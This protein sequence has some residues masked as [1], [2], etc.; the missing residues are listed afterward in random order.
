MKKNFL[1]KDLIKLRKLLLCKLRWIFC[2][3]VS[4]NFSLLRKCEVSGAG[5]RGGNGSPRNHCRPGLCRSLAAD[6]VPAPP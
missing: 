6:Y 4:A 5:R 2:L 3:S 1:L